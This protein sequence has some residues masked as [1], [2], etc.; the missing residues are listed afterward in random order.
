MARFDMTP[1]TPLS[2]SWPVEE[3]VTTFLRAV[4]GWM[5]GGLAITAVTASVIASS[6]A[7]VLAVATNRLLFWGL[8]IAQLGI[9]IVLSAR[10][11]QLAASTAALLFIAYS[12]LTGVTISFVLLAYTGESVATTFVIAAGMFGAMALYGT[13]DAAKSGGIRT[14]PVHGSH[15]RRPGI[16]RRYLLAQRRAAVRDL[17]RRGHRLYRPGC[18]R[19]TTD[20]VHGARVAGAARRALTR[21]SVRSRSTST[22]STCSS[23]CCALPAVGA[24]RRG[25]SG[26]V[27]DAFRRKRLPTPYLSAARWAL[28][29]F[30]RP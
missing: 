21:S 12:A 4:Y 23:S 10:V 29:M 25:V 3:R 15:R 26:V 1:D 13:T 28:R 20:E 11:Q 24:T 7:F 8:M 14:V 6:P 19:R 27:S 17:V 2:G 9:V 16:A 18:L 22:S 30:R 5:C